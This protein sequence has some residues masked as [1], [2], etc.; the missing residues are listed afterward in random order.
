[1][2]KKTIYPCRDCYD[3][4]PGCHSS[5]ERYIAHRAAARA[6]S[7]AVRTERDVAIMTD[8][9]EKEKSGRL[10]RAAE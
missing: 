5:C 10:K 8:R 2:R 9:Y 7:D 1:M 6:E 3:R 4:Q